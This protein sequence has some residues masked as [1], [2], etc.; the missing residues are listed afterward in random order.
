MATACRTT[1]VALTVLSLLACR[2]G[3]IVES[4]SD[5][6]FVGAWKLISI[7]RRSADGALIE[8]INPVGGEDPSG[9]VIYDRSGHV[10]LQIMPGHR[11]NTINTLQPLTPDEARDALIGYVAYFGTYSID[12]TAS[13]MHLHFDGSLNPSMVGTDG[14]RFYEFNGDRMTFRA[15]TSTTT[16]LTWERVK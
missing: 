6:P 15:G 14:G 3:P 8:G 9:M 1:G 7:E 10:S 12:P 13:V 5:N 4:A 16:R 11:V 2:E